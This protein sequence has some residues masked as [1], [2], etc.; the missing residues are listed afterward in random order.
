MGLIFTLILLVGIAAIIVW[1]ADLTSGSERRSTALDI[2]NQRLARDEIDR[3][4]YEDMLPILSA[5]QPALRRRAPARRS[6][7]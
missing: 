4:E 3:A 7:A 2:L 5:E 1:V 6:S